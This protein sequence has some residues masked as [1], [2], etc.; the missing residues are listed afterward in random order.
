VER[1][2]GIYGDE[3]TFTDNPTESLAQKFLAIQGFARTLMDAANKA[4]ALSLGRALER[5][6]TYANYIDA[7]LASVYTEIEKLKRG[8]SK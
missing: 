4:E 6:E 3:M 7:I 5:V 8:E 1:D 2:P